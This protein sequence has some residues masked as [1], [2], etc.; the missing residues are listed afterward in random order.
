M[1]VSPI[2]ILFASI[3]AAACGE[4]GTLSDAGAR[5][6]HAEAALNPKDAPG[7]ATSRAASHATEGGCAESGESQVFLISAL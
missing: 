2:L 5:A 7:R 6:D 4:V 3:L 1:T